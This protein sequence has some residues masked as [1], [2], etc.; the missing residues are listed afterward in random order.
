VDEEIDAY[1]AD[2]NRIVRVGFAHIIILSLLVQWHEMYLFRKRISGR[3]I[4]VAVY[5]YLSY[6]KP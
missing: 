1:R 2:E 3:Y 5:E 4:A 6:N